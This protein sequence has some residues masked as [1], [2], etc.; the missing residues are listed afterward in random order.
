M[1][2]PVCALGPKEIVVRALFHDGAV[3]HDEDEVSIANGGQAVGLSL[4][5]I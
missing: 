4:I 2:A 3:F 5:H 1:K